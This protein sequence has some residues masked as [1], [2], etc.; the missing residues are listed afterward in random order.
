MIREK[1]Y[2]SQ[3]IKMIEKLNDKDVKKII[4]III[5]NFKENE[6]KINN[7]NVFPVPDG[8]TGTNML[9]TLKSIQQEIGSLERF[10]FKNIGEKISYGALMGA[11]GNSGVILSQILKGFFDIIVIDEDI[12]VN[13]IRNALKSSMDLAYNS[14]QNPTE[15]TM[16]TTIKD[17]FK[18]VDGLNGKSMQYFD[19]LDL[20]INETEKSVMRTTFLLPVL[21]Q[22]GVVDAG[23]QG[24][25]DILNGFKKAL[26]NIDSNSTGKSIKKVA[27]NGQGDIYNSSGI[28]S[29]NEDYIAGEENPKESAGLKSIKKMEMIA[30]IKNI[31]CTELMI[32]GV[33][34][35]LLRLREDIES[36]GD[37]ALV[38]GN[39][40]LIKI[41]VHT[42]F[43][44]KVLNR[45]LREGTIHDIQI[46]NMVDQSRQAV[47][48]EIGHDEQ[49]SQKE[50]G[51]IAIANGDGFEEIFKSL[52]VDIVIKGGQSMNPSTYDIVKAINKLNCDKILILPNNKNIIL[53]ANQ[54]K[55]ISKKDVSVIQTTTIP[56]GI[57]AILGFNPDAS[58]QE[59]LENIESSLKYIKTGE[60]TTAVR[61]AN[62]YVGEIKKGAFIGLADGKVKTISDNLADAVIDLARDIMTSDN[63]IITIYFGEGADDDTNKIIKNRLLELYPGLEIEIHKG[64]QPLYPYIFSCE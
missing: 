60:V 62:L 56:Q 10:T 26:L 13:K 51:I 24:L 12:S 11:R 29:D 17:I 7:L 19:L 5:N 40:R 43:P 32:K 50:Y 42:N 41:H 34:I 45:A 61:D 38:V 63:E 6:S 39:D 55:K 33:N 28:S 18:T 59:N 48:V 20:I 36:F 58:L 2:L 54:A 37:S 57:G 16:L 25:L 52:G 8:D 30:D 46:N 27:G 31:Y 35:N 47:S 4:D 49:E 53:T 64:G 22:A 3:G 1:I 14:V 21:K 15:G 23:S 9:L 44:Q